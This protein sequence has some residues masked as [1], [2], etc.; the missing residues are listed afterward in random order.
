MPSGP[1]ARIAPCSTAYLCVLCCLWAPGAGRRGRRAWCPR[2][3]SGPPDAQRPASIGLV[4][5]TAYGH[6]ARGAG[7]VAHG[8]LGRLSAPRRASSHFHRRTSSTISLLPISVPFVSSGACLGALALFCFQ[9]CYASPVAE[10]RLA[11]SGIAYVM[12]REWCLAC[13]GMLDPCSGQRQRILRA[14]SVVG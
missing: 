1:S 7:D 14:S 3:P 5:G 13:L 6:G 11:L 8:A 2:A 10:R 9:R 4:A 12:T